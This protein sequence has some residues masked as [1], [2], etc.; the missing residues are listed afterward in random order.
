MY[1]RALACMLN[2]RTNGINWG[3][4]LPS[5]AR[6]DLKLSH[7]FF[8]IQN[9]FHYIYIYI[10]V[11]FRPH[12]D[13][14]TYYSIYNYYLH[15][16]HSVYT[17]FNSEA[18]DTWSTVSAMIR[19]HLFDNIQKFPKRRYSCAY[20]RVVFKPLVSR[21]FVCFLGATDKDDWSADRFHY[22]FGPDNEYDSNNE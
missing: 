22:I 10:L 13:F 2:Y 8:I 3:F 19:R 6:T 16:L 17:L 9:N 15:H 20:R 14:Q 18:F 7:E 12:Q 21:C 11:D 5:T 1:R 4:S